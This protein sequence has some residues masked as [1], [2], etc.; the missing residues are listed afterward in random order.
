MLHRIFAKHFTSWRKLMHAKLALTLTL[1]AL[2]GIAFAQI[3]VR[4]DS[5]VDAAAIQG[6]VNQFRADLGGAN[7]GVGAF[8]GSGG[9][10]EIN[11]D[12]VPNGFSSPNNLPGGFFNQNSQRGARFDTVGAGT[13]FQVSDS[14]T[15]NGAGV[16]FDNINNT[17]SGQFTT[18]SPQKL[19]TSLGN[20]VYD[21]RFFVPKTGPSSAGSNQALVSG[22]GAVF[23]DVDVAGTTAIQFFDIND[24]SLGGFAASPFSSGLSF[25]GGFTP[26]PQIARVRITMGNTVIGPGD[27]NGSSDIVVADDFI[28]GE[29]TSAAPEPGSLALLGLIA[30]PG[31]LVL[32]R[33]RR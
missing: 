31:A 18:F 28:Y 19:F 24:N 2:P 10:R 5:G 9:R 25:L 13:G 26:T 22:F 8:A 20:N 16:R 11:W 14:S 32:R 29:P 6:T 4:S 17:Y 12:A 23:A 1:A 3:T 21:V 27:N 7:N 30:V 15:G 33:Q